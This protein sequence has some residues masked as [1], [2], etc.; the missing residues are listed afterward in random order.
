ML[1]R[2][3]I[4]EQ[5]MD[6]EITY[7][8]D[9]DLPDDTNIVVKVKEDGVHIHLNPNKIYSSLNNKNIIIASINKKLTSLL[10]ELKSKVKFKKI[11]N[12]EYWDI[13]IKDVVYDKMKEPKEIRMLEAE[14]VLEGITRSILNKKEKEEAKRMEEMRNLEK[15]QEKIDKDEN[16]NKSRK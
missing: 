2:G 12:S 8:L 9:E 1:K 7:V 11:E 16:K 5:L 3:A 14:N 6:S 13:L 15:A 10:M 4:M